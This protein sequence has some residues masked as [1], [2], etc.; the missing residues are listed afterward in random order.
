M[1]NATI[2]VSIL[3]LLLAATPALSLETLTDAPLSLAEEAL[4][5]VVGGFGA[6]DCAAIIIGISLGLLF[7]GA[8]TVG[9]GLVVAG[10]YLPIA[11]AFC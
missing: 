4:A 3:G 6:I 11:A 1:K 7:I 2:I 9:A 10:A 5:N 8:V